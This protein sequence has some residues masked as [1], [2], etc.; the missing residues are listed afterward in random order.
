MTSQATISSAEMKPSLLAALLGEYGGADKEQFKLAALSSRIES[1]ISSYDDAFDQM[2]EMIQNAIDALS[3]QWRTAGEAFE[4]KLTVY[5]DEVQRSIAVLDN[6]C[7]VPEEHFHRVFE[8]GVS[9][10]QLLHHPDARGHKGAAVVYLQF[11]HAKFEFH[12]KS[13]GFSRAGVLENGHL[14]HQNLKDA[15]D[16]G[17]P[18]PEPAYTESG[19]IN[20]T[21]ATYS[22]GAYVRVELVDPD[23]CALFD[24][25]FT[26]P[27]L[28]IRDQIAVNRLEYLLRTRT[29]IGFVGG[30]PSVLKKMK[31]IHLEVKFKDKS[32]RTKDIDIGFLYP[33]LD[34]AIASVEILNKGYPR[35]LDMLY[36]EWSPALLGLKNVL[37]DRVLATKRLQDI[38]AEFQP[39][40]YFCYTARN[41][42]YE[43]IQDRY[44]V[45]AD[46]A[47]GLEADLR[48]Y[49]KVTGINGGFLVAVQGFPNGRLQQFIQRGGSEDKSRTFVVINFNAKYVP[50]YGR[51]SLHHD[52][53]PF[54]N[55]LCKALMAFASEEKKGYLPTGSKGGAG[56]A[57]AAGGLANA[58]E[59]CKS[60][61]GAL[62]AR[63]QTVP[64]CSG[65]IKPYFSP[66]Y[67]GDVAFQFMSFIRE[68]KLKG[69]RIFGFPTAYTYDGLFDYEIEKAAGE[70]RKGTNELGVLFG[71]KSKIT[72]TGQWLEYKK[73]CDQLV[74]EMEL[75]DGSPGKKWYELLNL[76]VCD[77]LDDQYDGY[78]LTAI[79]SSS[80][81]ERLYFG[82]THILK[83][84]GHEH[85]I[86]VICLSTLRTA[87]TVAPPPVA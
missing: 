11:D 60:E 56:G 66:E 45:F 20:E 31:T 62:R 41:P 22:S 25:I 50:D 67:E 49:L 70:Y 86:Q 73:S 85:A 15:L 74:D 44:C 10:K 34:S 4:P 57:G 30:L 33:H 65:A 83:K 24:G 72:L 17:A 14:W 3:Q 76:L 68:N 47:V 9:I 71:V 29:G 61:E 87:F 46:G 1:I 58:R 7:G 55:E 48:E 27:N 54:V 13:S 6:G 43:S 28:A 81:N 18:T 78:T 69:F 40:G 23:A 75:D 35:I 42:L 21:L 59:N 19:G 32:I 53:R 37:K 2:P 63:Y 26:T 64:F 5:I 79:D 52:C 16:N 82:V 39:H 8:P 84:V 12:T 36:Q 77:E 51:K 38:V 80:L